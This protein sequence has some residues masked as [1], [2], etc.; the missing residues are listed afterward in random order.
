MLRTSNDSSDNELILSL[1]SGSQDA[2]AILYA[3]YGSLVYTIAL[4]ILK[5]ST[6]AED[7]TQEIFINFWKKEK[8][9]SNRA[10]L[11][12]YLSIMTRSRALNRL[13]S[14]SSQ[15]QS[16]Q[17]LHQSLP[18]RTDITPLEKASLLEQQDVVKQ[19]LSNLSERQRQILD[20]NFYQGISHSE[21]ARQLEIPLGTVKTTARK[22]LVEL[23]KMLGDAVQ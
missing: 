5:K 12:T 22:G 21:I 10:A 11:S 2:L 14:Q 7:L 23:R 18:T 3:R 13:S 9:D 4:R 1:R 17:R 19:A 15:Q 6:E 16:I 20:M 8:F